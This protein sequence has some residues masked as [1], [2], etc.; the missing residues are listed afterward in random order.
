M[1][2]AL[3]ALAITSISVK[4]WSSPAASNTRPSRGSIGRRASCCP[5]RVSW[6]VWSTAPN[7]RSRWY[8]SLMA[9]LVGGSSNG[10]VSKVPKRRS[11]KR[12]MTPAKFAR[13]SSGS[14]C[15]GRRVKSSSLYSRTQTPARSRPQRPAR[16]AALACATG[17]VGSRCS[18]LRAP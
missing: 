11:A 10:K 16:W 13:R 18:L 2:P 14:V 15:A 4:Q 9:R 12:R 3:S 1:S 6:R 7:S 8:P 5:Q 17:S